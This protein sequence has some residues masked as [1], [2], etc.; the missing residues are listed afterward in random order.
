MTDVDSFGRSTS[1][2]KKIWP[3]SIALIGLVLVEGLFWCR[4][5]GVILEG[6]WPKM[7]RNEFL[8]MKINMTIVGWAFFYIF[9]DIYECREW[10]IS[11]E[12]LGRPKKVE[13][14]CYQLAVE[15]LKI[16]IF[17]MAIDDHKLC[18]VRK[19]STYRSPLS[20]MTC[21]TGK[22]IISHIVETLNK[23]DCHNDEENRMIDKTTMN[24]SL[25]NWP[26]HGTCGSVV[27]W[28]YKFNRA[29]TN[30]LAILANFVDMRWWLLWN[31]DDFVKVP[32]ILGYLP[33]FPMVSVEFCWF[34]MIFFCTS[35]TF[36][37]LRKF[38]MTFFDFLWFFINFVNFWWIFFGFL[39][40]SI[41]FVGFW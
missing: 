32:L 16:H 36:D 12:A 15:S 35:M 38:F 6:F 22:I 21:D 8:D 7:S 4:V 40:F 20:H 14:C 31:Y 26:T 17:T 24:L 9:W 29:Y 27:M 23:T 11:W 18:K 30:F 25:I 19:A 28:N 3:K 1:V 2:E 13:F 41:N 5:F 34:L 33:Q 39:W 37:Q 10:W